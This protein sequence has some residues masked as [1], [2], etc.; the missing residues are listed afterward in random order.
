MHL[1]H[2]FAQLKV[3]KLL[4]TYKRCTFAVESLDKSSL[5][6]HIDAIFGEGNLAQ[7]RTWSETS[8]QKGS[9]V[10][11]VIAER[12]EHHQ[13]FYAGGDW[14]HCLF[15]E[16]LKEERLLLERFPRALDRQAYKITLANSAA[17]WILITPAAPSFVCDDEASPFAPTAQLTRPPPSSVVSSSLRHRR[18][19]LPSKTSLRL[20]LNPPS[21]T[22][23]P[24]VALSKIQ[25]KA[26]RRKAARQNSTS[27]SGNPVP[28]SPSS[29]DTFFA[30]AVPPFS[31]SPAELLSRVRAYLEPPSDLPSSVKLQTWR[32]FLANLFRHV[33]L[34]IPALAT[35][36]FAGAGA[37]NGAE[38]DTF[39]MKSVEAFLDSLEERIEASEASTAEAGNSEVEKLWRSLKFA[40]SSLSEKGRIRPRERSNLTACSV[41]GFSPMGWP[42][43][44][45]R[46]ST[47][48]ATK[49]RASSY[50][51]GESGGPPTPGVIARSVGPPLSLQSWRKIK[52][53]ESKE[54]RV[55]GKGGRRKKTVYV[56]EWERAWMYVKLPHDEPRSQLLLDALSSL[57][58]RS[59]IWRA[60]PPAM[61][62]RTGFPRSK[63]VAR[64]ESLVQ[65]GRAMDHLDS[66][67][68]RQD[69]FSLL[70]SSPPETHFHAAPYSD[71]I[72]CPTPRRTRPRRTT[73]GPRSPRA[74]HRRSLPRRGAKRSSSWRQGAGGGGQ[75]GRDETAKLVDCLEV[76]SSLATVSPSVQPWYKLSAFLSHFYSDL[77]NLLTEERI[78][79][80]AIF[81]DPIPTLS[82]FIQTTLE[83]LT[84]SFPHRLTSIADAYGPGVLPEV[85]LAFKATEE[86][87]VKVERIF[88]KLEP[89]LQQPFSPS[90]SP[91]PTPPRPGHS[92]SSPSLSSGLSPTPNKRRFSKRRSLS[93]RLSA[94]SISFAAGTSPDFEST[95]PD[96]DSE[97]G[98]D[99]GGEGG[100]AYVRR[101]E[102]ALFEPF[103]DWQVKYPELERQFLIAEQRAQATVAQLTGGVGSAEEEQE[104]VLEG[105][106]YPTEDWSTFQFGLKLFDTCRARSERW[107]SFE[108][109]ARMTVLAHSIREAREHPTTYTI[110]GTAKG[111]M[112]LLRQSTLNS[113][114]LPSLLDPLEKR[115]R[116]PRLGCTPLRPH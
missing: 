73:R 103:L 116:A 67:P 69:P 51:A 95:S 107:A 36:T 1:D 115:P 18:L 100:A 101:W 70:R 19:L 25:S 94:R 105:L 46:H 44:A 56:E 109:K 10:R 7:L 40:K 13:Q 50:S 112:L 14:G 111:Q 79:L 42:T 23:S 22:P 82:S 71:S 59:A 60:R 55:K 77:H 89:P 17:S 35:L 58:S 76:P 53:V 64:A 31:A 91:I 9:L 15:V 29:D 11:R 97:N 39:R 88:A 99:E 113:A 63:K 27:T 62:L 21:S 28:T 37:V 26:A 114:E 106:E 57:P 83:G 24:P 104:R 80:P 41:S 65:Y 86:F 30:V 61:R 43:Y 16:T 98:E 4:K 12:A 49:T 68:A 8:R 96:F 66:L 84:P 6:K 74:S 52:R 87:A 93:R 110:S 90:P 75:E 48:P 38:G 72:D 102:T 81:P 47:S 2:P 45:A 54:K 92:P 33:V 20:C 34:R 85:I 3:A 32:T 78:Y 5:P 108:F